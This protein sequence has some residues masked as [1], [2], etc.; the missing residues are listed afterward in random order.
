MIEPMT[1]KRFESV[2]N[3]WLRPGIIARVAE[4]LQNGGYDKEPV[5]LSIT[6]AALPSAA[7]AGLDILAKYYVDNFEVPPDLIDLARFYRTKISN[8]IWGKISHIRFSGNLRFEF[9]SQESTPM[10]TVLEVVG[11]EAEIRLVH[12]PLHV[13]TDVVGQ[14]AVYWQGVRTKSDPINIHHEQRA[15]WQFLAWVDMVV[16]KAHGFMLVGKAGMTELR[17]DYDIE[18]IG[19]FQSARGPL[20]VTAEAQSQLRLAAMVTNKPYHDYFDDARGRSHA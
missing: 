4:D 18:S 15:E 7:S 20:P 5:A 19:R 8:E 6:S 2:L 13:L 12:W 14:L 1:P 17:H 9:D 11:P 10:K 16:A 3:S